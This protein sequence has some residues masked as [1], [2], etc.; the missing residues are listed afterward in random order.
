MIIVGKVS[1]VFGVKGQVKVFSYTDPM[2]N[3]L[4][5]APWHLQIKGDWL[6]Q[7][8]LTGQRHGK[9]IIARLKGFDDRDLAQTLVGVKIGISRE[10]LPEAASDEYYWS[11]LEGLKVVTTEGIE[12]GQVD[13]LFET[14]SNDVLVVKGDKQR[15]LP[16][17]R[18]Q[19]IKQIDLQAGQMIV[20]W[21]PEF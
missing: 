16:Y 1:G 18:D 15:L 8:V 4:H 14:G 2:E 5:Y 17:I 7:E 11:D 21:D 6:E 20:D 9:G 12:L 10:Q 13:Y 3:I 19:V